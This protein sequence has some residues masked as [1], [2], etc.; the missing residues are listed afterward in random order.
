MYYLLIV[1]L[2]EGQGTG[3]GCGLGTDGPRQ[4]SVSLVLA[5]S[6]SCPLEDEG[7]WSHRHMAAT[8]SLCRNTTIVTIFGQVKYMRGLTYCCL[9][10]IM[11][12]CRA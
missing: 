8:H 4:A 1:C 10:V 7:V 3:L 5:V 6:Q 9:S 12:R 11:G 2:P